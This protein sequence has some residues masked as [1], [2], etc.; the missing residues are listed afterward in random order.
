MDKRF[1]WGKDGYGKPAL[2][3]LGLYVGCVIPCDAKETR[4]RAWLM[5]DDEGESIGGDTI[6]PDNF[7]T[8]EAAQAALYAAALARVTETEKA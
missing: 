8:A 7:P 1:T 5:L 4:W 6:G 3:L 2:F